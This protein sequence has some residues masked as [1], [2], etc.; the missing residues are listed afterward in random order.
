MKP[1]VKVLLAVFVLSTAVLAC[2]SNEPV[3]PVPTPTPFV[4]Q[5]G[6]DVM[7]QPDVGPKYSTNQLYDEALQIASEIIGFKVDVNA[8]LSF[9]TFFCALIL[10]GLWLGVDRQRW[11]FVFVVATIVGLLGGL[12]TAAGKSDAIK[13]F[14]YPIAN[15]A[16]TGGVDFAKKAQS[17][18]YQYIY[19]PIKQVGVDSMVCRETVSPDTTSGY[20][21]SDQ[22]AFVSQYYTH[23]RVDE[24]TEVEYHH[25]CSTDSDGHET[26]RDWTEY[27]D[28]WRDRYTPWFDHL[29]RTY[30]IPATKAKYLSEQIYKDKYGMRCLADNGTFDTCTQDSDGIPNDQRSPVIYA[31]VDWRAP[32]NATMHFY[33]GTYGV[34]S[35]NDHVPDAYAIPLARAQHGGNLYVETF[36]GPYFNWGLASEDTMFMQYAGH[37]QDLVNMMSLPGP[38]G[39]TF[40]INDAYGKPM[41]LHTMLTSSDGDL[42]VGYNPVFQIGVDLDPSFIADAA[43]TAMLFQGDF[44]P[45]PT[46]HGAAVWF[47]VGKSVVDGLG[48]MENTIS[49][50]KAY[51]HDGD[52][53]GLFSL[54]KNLV[55]IVTEVSDDGKKILSR[56]METGMPLGN[57]V[58][59]QDMRSSIKT[60]E[61][62]PLT[63][64]NLIGSFTATYK[65]TNGNTFEY[66]YSNLSD[67]GG[68]ASVLYRPSDYVAPDTNS[69]EC[70][71]ASVD[72]PGFILYSMCALEYQ[73][74]NIKINQEG[75]DLIMTGVKND[76][77]NT[78]STLGHWIWFFVVI[79]LIIVTIATKSDAFI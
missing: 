27:T 5:Q 9:A 53:W 76:A 66:E 75:H 50:L 38:N 16:I 56:G 25:D 60:G 61:S 44:G 15:K 49:A 52:T 67:A 46:K 21:P 32:Q 57:Q 45:N 78:V 74:S 11:Q 47:V 43:N 2:G 70:A 34:G 64:E 7:T 73:Q 41:A 8:W 39:V 1:L 55:I 42:P 29:E 3:A 4:V 40:H 30:I 72:H 63:V 31:S 33:P 18:N 48:G 17:T 71:N 12:A 58:V 24:W 22:C 14:G 68:A 77:N 10:F 23:D 36:I 79:V 59:I 19:A 6:K 28:H 54:P 69:T 65:P 37:Y 20:G 13:S 26:C 62:L 35:Y 51:L